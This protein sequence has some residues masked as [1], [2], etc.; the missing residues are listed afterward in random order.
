MAAKLSEDRKG[1]R[2]TREK[3]AETQGKQSIKLRIK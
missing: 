2:A 1:L 3:T